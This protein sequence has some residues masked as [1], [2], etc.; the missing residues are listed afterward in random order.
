MAGF[1]LFPLLVFGFATRADLGWVE[2]LYLGAIL[3]LLPFLSV[4]QVPL[5]AFAELDRMTAYLNSAVVLF[6]V[7]GAGLLIGANALGAEVMG[8]AAPEAE[9]FLPWSLYLAGAIVLV[10]GGSW[11]FTRATGIGDSALLRELLPRDA[12]ER[13]AFLAVSVTAGVSEEVAFRGYAIPTLEGLLGGSWYAVAFTSAVFGIL[14]AYQGPLG[15]VRTALIGAVMGA[16]FVLSGS[17]WPAIFIHVVLDIVLG[18]GLGEKL[19]GDL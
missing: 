13:A 1:L 11:L 4:A 6:V 16:S 10:Q 3:Q 19:L 5:F 15:I 14:H 18:L 7:G 2:A 17:L 8:L 9:V 12:R